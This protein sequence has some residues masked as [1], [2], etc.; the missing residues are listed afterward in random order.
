MKQKIRLISVLLIVM[1]VFSFAFSTNAQ[2][3]KYRFLMVSHIGSNDPN[4]NW[5]T[6]AIDDFT[7]RF[8]E[9]EIEYISAPNSTVED[10]VRMAREALATN[11]DGIAIPIQSSDALD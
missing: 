1:L 7:A 4:M 9:V 10:L 11:P 5:L 3:K 6:F 2:D 8:P